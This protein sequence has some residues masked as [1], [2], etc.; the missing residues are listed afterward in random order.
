VRVTIIG[1][2]GL[3]PRLVKHWADRLPTLSALLGPRE[4]DTQSVF[5]PDSIPAW[6][7]VFTGLG[8]AEHGLLGYVDYL[9]SS[10]L[11]AGCRG[12]ADA[13]RGQ[14]FWDRASAAGY[15]VCILNPFLAFPP[16]EVNGLMVSGPVGAGEAASSPPGVT[17]SGS[18]APMIGGIPDFPGRGQLESFAS[19]T[20]RDVDSLC[21]FA[22]MLFR[23]DD[24]DLRFV[25]FLQLDRVQHF[26][27]RHMDAGDCTHPRN[28]RYSAVIESFYLQFDRIV[29]RLTEDCGRDE[30]IVV[31]SDHG[32]RRRCE[33]VLNVNEIL[34]RAGLL[35]PRTSTGG[36]VGLRFLLERAKSLVLRAAYRL[37]L[38]EEAYRLA[39]V[40]PNRR[41]LKTSEHVIGLAESVARASQF[42]GTNPFGGVIVDREAAAAR[43]LDYDETVALVVGLLSEVEVE[44]G[45]QPVLWA[46]SRERVYDGPHAGRFPDV[47]FELSPE[48]GVGFALFD[49][50]SGP[51]TM[52]RR[53]SG[54]HSRAAFF[55]VR[56]P[57]IPYP[58]PERLEDSERQA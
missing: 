36:L 7:T 5:P 2:D 55:G 43:G 23:A 28:G 52:H 48:F 24:Y 25:T 3:D 40:L 46:E 22:E 26:F 38:E 27:W 12:Y 49:G 44:G 39:R 54:G 34:R 13:L 45:M 42:G 14:T 18:D 51:N 30:A 17:P 35:V 56:S 10:A 31:V 9:S 41:A 32:Q 29:A 8:P 21:D 15:R 50:L 58:T 20:A 1:I 19:R 6:A 11:E 47:I 57:W 53:I 16:W 37:A 4:V 33:R